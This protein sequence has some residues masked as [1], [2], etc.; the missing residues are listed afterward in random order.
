[1]EFRLLSPE[2]SLSSRAE[3]YEVD[4][5][6]NLELPP[7]PIF[8]TTEQAKQVIGDFS[9]MV[10]DM[11]VIGVYG[12]GS[13]FVRGAFVDRMNELKLIHVASIRASPQEADTRTRLKKDITD[14]IYYYSSTSSLE[15]NDALKILIVDGGNVIEQKHNA[16]YCTVKETHQNAYVTYLYSKLIID[17]IKA[18]RFVILD[19]I[20]ASSFT[21]GDKRQVRP[22]L[23]RCLRTQADK[24]S[25]KHALLLPPYLESP[26]LM[27]GVAA[28]ILTMLEHRNL[29]GILLCSLEENHAL[30]QVTMKAFEK[31]VFGILVKQTGSEEANSL[32]ATPLSPLT[33][34]SALKYKTLSSSTEHHA[35]YL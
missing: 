8:E 31:S 6:E 26:N 25:F 33:P 28:S 4:E 17:N 21:A 5:E 13:Q 3:D 32:N 20:L 2:L 11:V 24:N 10:F 29:N 18:N 35:L 16:Q 12:A 22:P 7:S 34:N 19:S 9:N 27:T 23:L 30:E 15:S 14:K 1:M